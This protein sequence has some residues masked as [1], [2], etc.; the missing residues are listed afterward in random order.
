MFLKL[1]NNIM[2]WYITAAALSILTPNPAI[3]L[4]L[5]ATIA[6][7]VGNPLSSKTGKASKYLLQSAVI[8]LGFGT[9]FAAVMKVGM[10]S[11]WVTMISILTVFLLGSIYGRLFKV[12]QDLSLLVST[13]T[14]I[15]GGSAIAAMSPAIGASETDTAVSMAVI[16]LLNGIAL[17]VFPPLG[18]FFGMGQEQFGFWAALA[19]HDTSSVVGAGAIYGA[20]ALA[21]AT[22]VKLTRA[23]WILPV[24]FAGAKLRGSNSNATFPWF[25][26]G[27]L[28][29]AGIRTLFPQLEE[30]CKIGAVTGKH[31]MSGTL[32]LVGAGLGMDK[33]RKIG[34][35]PLVM[36][37]GLWISVSIITLIA[38]KMNLMPS[39]A[40]II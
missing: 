3:G 2:F 12:E 31:M 4:A 29:A 19:I 35:R 23:M 10:A 9:H 17:I 13:G 8:L 36:A 5:G 25:L 7:T 32:F 1:T 24:S 22:T 21:I 14:A 15:C 6:L 20:E 33:L 39:I 27:F 11:L 38:I 34:V 16:F 26:L 18:H 40:N 37:I 28:A 30:F